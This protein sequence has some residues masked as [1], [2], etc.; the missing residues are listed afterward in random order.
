MFL[1]KVPERENK[2]PEG[3]P[4]RQWMTVVAGYL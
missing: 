1:R 2:Y 3:F 4:R